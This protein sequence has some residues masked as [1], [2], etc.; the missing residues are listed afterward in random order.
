MHKTNLTRETVVKRKISLFALA[1]TCCSFSLGSCLVEV[2]RVIGATF[3][4]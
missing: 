2:A 3:F 4:F 1:T